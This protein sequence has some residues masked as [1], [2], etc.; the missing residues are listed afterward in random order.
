MNKQEAKFHTKIMTWL[1]HN[2]HKLPKSFLIET[3]IVRIGS[4][5]FPYKELSEKEERLLLRAKN[6]VVM[7]THSDLGGFGTNCDAS[8]IS[9]GGYIFISW[10][11]P[12]NKT[13]YIIDIEDFI[14]HRN[15]SKTKSL[16]EDDAIKIAYITENLC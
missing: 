8:V 7:Q 11:R 12:R 6:G 5:T 15:S 2:Y 1:S 9:G 10:N 14:K 3:K 16:T 4:N 13:F